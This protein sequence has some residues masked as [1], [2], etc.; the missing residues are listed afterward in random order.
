[1]IYD[2]HGFDLLVDL[3]TWQ[4]LDIPAN[5]LIEFS[6]F[7]RIGRQG[8]RGSLSLPA[9]VALTLYLFGCL[10]SLFRATCI[11]QDSNEGPSRGMA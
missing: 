11:L 5:P 2:V 6:G 8:R 9:N 10:Q 1:M 3:P 4:I 7:L